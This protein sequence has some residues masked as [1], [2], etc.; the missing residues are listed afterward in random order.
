MTALTTITPDGRRF[1]FSGANDQQRE[2]S[3]IPRAEYLFSSGGENITDGDADGQV[4]K[5]VM[6]LPK[7]F[8]Y[9][10]VDAS[11]FLQCTVAGQANN[12]DDTAMLVATTSNVVY[13]T[14]L[15]W[16]QMC[17]HGFVNS[18]GTQLRNSRAY[19]VHRNYEPKELFWD[20]DADEPS[21]TFFVN[22]RTGLET[23]FNIGFSFRFLQYDVAQVFNWEA[24]TPL[25]T[26]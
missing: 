4:V 3:N 8:A 24:N 21:F 2:I 25:L 7:A 15:F 16:T 13:P 5:I 10:L 20:A 1:P 6:N 26:R 17:S 22:N 23:D 11:A 9:A 12:F 18:A 14:R 19:N